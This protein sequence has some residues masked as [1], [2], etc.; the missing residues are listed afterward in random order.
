[1]SG[2]G[3][4]LVSGILVA[5]DLASGRLVRPFEIDFATDFTYYLVYPE[6]YAER[7]QVKAF[8][9]WLLSAVAGSEG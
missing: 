1:M 7:A 4:V 3:V 6:R 2:Q 8:R 5:D 9:D